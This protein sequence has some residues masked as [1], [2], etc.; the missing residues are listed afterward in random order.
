VCASIERRPAF[1]H[2]ADLVDGFTVNAEAGAYVQIHVCVDDVRGDHLGDDEL[3][4][5]R[6]RRGLDSVG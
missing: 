5:A 3:R 6:E 1:D 2:P 4:A